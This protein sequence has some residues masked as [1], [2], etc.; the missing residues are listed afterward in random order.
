MS[1]H[2]GNMKR[3]HAKLLARYGADDDLV[4]Q[5]SKELELLEV[6]ESKRTHSFIPR[7]TLRRKADLS[8]QPLAPQ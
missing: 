3:L 6:I 4:L 8:V 7:T 2:I 1:K 5:V